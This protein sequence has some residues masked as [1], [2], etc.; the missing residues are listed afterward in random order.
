MGRAGSVALAASLL[1]ITATSPTVGAGRRAA[2]AAQ[3]A[4]STAIVPF[5]IHVPDAVLVDLQDRLAKVRY[6]AE[7]DESGWRYGANLAYMKE[8]VAYWRERYDWRAQERRLNRF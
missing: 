7:I 2:P 4:E 8:L 3:A 1:L 5:E 6:P